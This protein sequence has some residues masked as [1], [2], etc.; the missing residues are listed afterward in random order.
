MLTTL[1]GRI[2]RCAHCGGSVVKVDA[3]GCACAADKIVGARSG[4]GI[5]ARHE[6][7]ARVGSGRI[8]APTIDWI[9]R[10]TLRR[11]TQLARVASV[12]RRRAPQQQLDR[13]LQRL[14]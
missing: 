9:E 10:E 7:V 1:L 8:G 3:R 4:R 14:V 6:Y 13:E 5:A 2:V 12:D 11:A